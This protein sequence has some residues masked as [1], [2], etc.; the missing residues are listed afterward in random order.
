MCGIVGIVDFAGRAIDEQTLGRMTERL[1]HRGPDDQATEIIRL[2]KMTVGLGFTRLAVIDPTPRGNQPMSLTTHVEPNGPPYTIV[3]N[4]EIYNYRELRRELEAE[5]RTFRSDCDTEVLLAAY[6]HWGS[7]AFNRCNGMWACCIINR[8]SGLGVLARDRFGIK[9][10]YWSCTGDRLRF[11]GEMSALLAD[12]EQ[13]RDI[14]ACGLGLYL[15]L[16][17]VP[18][19][20]SILSGV[21]TLPP[22]HLL[23]FDTGTLRQP[24]PYYR[25]PAVEGGALDYEECCR[26]L[27]RRIERAVVDRLVADVPLGAFLSGGVDSSIIVAHMT[28]HAAGPVRTCAIGFADEPRYDETHYARAVAQHFGTEHQEF[29]LTYADVIAALPGLLTH[30]GEPFG[31]ASLLPTALVSREAR[32]FVTV[33]LSG[34]AGDELFAGYWRYVGH[35]YLQRYR[36]LP[37]R[38]RQWLIEPLLARMRVGK[39]HAL[40][41]RAR[42]MRKMLRATSSDMLENHLAWAQILAPE[43]ADIFADPPDLARGGQELAELFARAASDA[44]ADDPLNRILRV[45]L[46]VGLPGDMLHKVDLASMRHSLE[47]RVPLLDYRVVEYVTALPSSYKLAGKQTKR[48]LRDAYR[49]VLPADVLAR[50]KMGFELPI[51]EFL[52]AE[53]R[54]MFHDTVTKDTLESIGPFNHAAVKRLYDDHLHHRA[55]HADLLYALLALCWWK[56]HQ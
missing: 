48:L 15:R 25:L 19:P 53:L 46:L 45:D 21:H 16:G 44:P 14:D 12:A 8:H 39:A 9:P 33:A 36:L 17:Y 54:D 41:D 52:R 38:V 22:G 28:E 11:A 5:G 55:E 40:G 51:G 3:F 35:H 50:P 31:D 49:D 43:A 2:G 24:E 18:H 1:A 47:V 34:D 30:V 32:K 10:L 23:R 56:Q 13:P 4:G 37:A 20:F 6:M 42:Q 27:R 29:R 7:Q 26:E